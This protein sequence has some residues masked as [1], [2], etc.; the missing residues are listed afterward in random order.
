MRRRELLAA[1][2]AALAAASSPLPAN[3][4]VKWA[5]SLALWMRFK[6]TPVESILDLMKETGFIGV[7]I[8]GNPQLAKNWNTTPAILGRELR[9]RN[10]RAAAI[11]FSGPLHVPDQRKKVL[12]DARASLELLKGLGGR[13]M[14][15]FTPARLQDKPG[16]EVKAAFQEVVERANQ[17]GEIAGAMGMT[18]G[19]HNHL[20]QMVEQG[21]E[22]DRFLSRTDPKLVGFSP[23]TAHLHL[24]GANVLDVMKKHRDR[25]GGSMDYKDAKWTAP[26]SDFTDENGRVYKKD[27]KQ[28]RFL[29][30]IYD[31]GDGEVNFPGCQEILKS[32]EYKGWLCVDLDMARQGPRKSYERCG[33]YVV[34]KLEPIYK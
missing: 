21:R 16:A 8:I 32:L 5:L 27:S 13:H 14:V 25:I 18:V 4:N 34:N 12:D 29:N 1:G 17:V 11:A 28:A 20:D 22:I 15:L 10:L 31:L 7:R 3:K 24:A 23:D 9:K 19:V 33:A 2:G 26:T 30:S 6:P